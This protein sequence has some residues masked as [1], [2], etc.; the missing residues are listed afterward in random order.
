[1]KFRHIFYVFNY[2]KIKLDIICLRFDVTKN[3]TFLDYI[4]EGLQI[5]FVVAID[6]TGSNG[7]PENKESLHYFQ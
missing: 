7:H 2:S 3:K 5:N 1:M 4:Q 6:F